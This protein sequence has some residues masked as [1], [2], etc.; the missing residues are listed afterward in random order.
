MLD[1]GPRAAGIRP[2]AHRTG[3]PTGSLYHRFGSRDALMAQAW[4][5]AVRRFQNG[6]LEAL[7]TSDPHE[8]V[9]GAA[10]WGISFVLAEPADAL[11]LLNHS[12]ASLLD[13]DPAPDVARALQTVNE[14][15]VAAVANLA[16]RLFG[17]RDSTAV[18]RVTYAVVDLPYAVVRRHLLA[19]T[20][21][22]G[23]AVDVA[24]AAEA[25]IREPC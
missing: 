2:I 19:G 21:T 12:P 13:A 16:G 7:G 24:R 8:A 9:S 25:I 4:L 20:L 5:R 15:V 14:P 1:G 18:E 10:A 23:T 17:A 6:F 22:A 3:A 11:L